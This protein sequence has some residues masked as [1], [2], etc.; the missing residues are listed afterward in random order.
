MAQEAISE[1]RHKVH[2][3]THAKVIMAVS[4]IIELLY[5][6][7]G[8]IALTMNI[9]LIDLNLVT[10]QSIMLIP[11][12]VLALANFIFLR[13]ATRNYSYK[14]RVI[15][16]SN[17]VFCWK[18]ST[19]VAIILSVYSIACGNLIVD[20]VI[21]VLFNILPAI[22]SYSLSSFCVSSKIKH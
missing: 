5:I 6:V 14:E 11:H 12:T 17:L 16:R 2:Y 9:R 3:T 13:I 7:I 8:P 22:T 4:G 10:L 18:L 19:S 15:I 20:S 21:T 1:T